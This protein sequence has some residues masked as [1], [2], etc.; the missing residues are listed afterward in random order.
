MSIKREQVILVLNNHPNIGAQ[1]TKKAL[2]AF[3]DLADKLWKADRVE[4]EKRLGPKIA[5]FIL[6]SRTYDPDE[7]TDEL[8]RLNI[9]HITMYDKEY[10]TLLKEIPDYPAIL[11]VKGSLLSLK[12]PSVAIV[13]SRKYSSYGARV[14]RKISSDLAV[15]NVTVVSGLALGIDAAAHQATLEA[16]GQTIGVLGCGLDKIYPINN[17]RLAEQMVERGGAV[18]SEYPPGTEPYKSN[19]PARN[20][21]IAGA[22]LGTVV[23]EAAEE[24]GALITALAALEYNRSVFAVPG[25]IDAD[26]SRGS[27]KLIQQGAKLITSVE[28][29]FEDLNLETKKAEQNAKE[30]LPQTKEQKAIINCIN[31]STKNI[32]EIVREC[33][34]NVAIISYTLTMLEMKGI[35]ENVG[36]MWRKKL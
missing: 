4:L 3:G 30:F 2:A 31:D 20:R 14:A 29:I 12:K 24:S 11:Y 16:G 32:D 1:T 13:G 19:F 22:T 7:I 36:G 17:T 15:N 33:G 8:A 9:G 6:E 23:V 18:I 34:Y 10:P 21:I 25:Q 26:T 35:L 5:G 27:N 28:D